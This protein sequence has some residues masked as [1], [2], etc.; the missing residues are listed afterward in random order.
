M[1]QEIDKLRRIS[2]R[3]AGERKSNRG[4][5]ANSNPSKKQSTQNL[6]VRPR[7]SDFNAGI[8]CLAQSN[9][10]PKVASPTPCHLMVC[11]FFVNSPLHRQQRPAGR[12][13]IHDYIVYSQGYLPAVLQNLDR[14]DYI[15]MISDSQDGK[16]EEFMEQVLFTRL[17][18]MM[19]M[20]L[21]EKL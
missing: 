15:Q 6:P 10:S 3:M 4:I 18:E 2:I 11:I 8:F 17:Q 9:T 14:K 12:T 21:I 1:L 7:D 16:P 19:R 5:I 20:N 13:F